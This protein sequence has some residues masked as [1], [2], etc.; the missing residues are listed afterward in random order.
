MKSSI[1]WFHGLLSTAVE[2][3]LIL[4]EINSTRYEKAIIYAVFNP[5]RWDNSK[6]SRSCQKW[7]RIYAGFQQ[8]SKGG[9]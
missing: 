7:Q 9:L 1:H 8:E 5:T 2:T 4:F 3:P 6:S